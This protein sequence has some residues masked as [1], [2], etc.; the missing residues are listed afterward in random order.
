MARRGTSSGR[1]RNVRK[2]AGCGKPI[3]SG[4]YCDQ[5]LEKLREQAKVQGRRLEM[6]KRNDL[7]RVAE[8]K[9]EIFVLVSISS[10]QVINDIDRQA[11][12]AHHKYR[13]SDYGHCDPPQS[14]GN[15]YLQ[16]IRLP[17]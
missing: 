2:C 7:R 17:Q 16:D 9:N 1:N 11:L 6:M 15:L 8:N 5:C 4:L 12:S 14:R 13:H 10:L 3:Q